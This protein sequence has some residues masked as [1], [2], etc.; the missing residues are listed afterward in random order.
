MLTIVL[1]GLGSLCGQQLQKTAE[2]KTSNYQQNKSLKRYSPNFV[3]HSKNSPST[4]ST[5]LKLLDNVLNN[6]NA[7]TIQV[8][9][10]L[11]HSIMQHS[12]FVEY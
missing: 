2:R 3:G 9:I 7:I 12:H 6:V 10:H 8:L 4:N 5:V 11:P 1:K